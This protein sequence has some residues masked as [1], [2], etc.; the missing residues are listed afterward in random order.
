MCRELF[1]LKLIDIAVAIICLASNFDSKNV[2]G[3]TENSLNLICKKMANDV[4]ESINVSAS[5][6]SLKSIHLKKENDFG[7]HCNS[8]NSSNFNENGLN[9]LK[10]T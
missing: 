8:L 4:I 10:L 6:K 7:S 1:S 9:M 2:L 3:F 5:R